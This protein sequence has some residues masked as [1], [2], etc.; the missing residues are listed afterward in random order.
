MKNIVITFIL[1]TFTIFGSAQEKTKATTIQRTPE[2]KTQLLNQYLNLLTSENKWLGSVYILQDG[3]KLYSYESGYLSDEKKEKA[4]ENT[5]Y[6][7][8]SVTK[9]FTASLIYQLI[10]RKKLTLDTKLSKFYPEIKH[11]DKITI[12]H[13][14]GHQ[15]GIFNYTNSDEIDFM[16]EYSKEEM[17]TVLKGMKSTFEPGKDQQYSNSNYILLGF[18]I[19]DVL[20]M[21]LEKAYKKYIFSKG[22]YTK[23]M[24]FEQPT[25]VAKNYTHSFIWNEEE[26]TWK[27]VEPWGRSVAGAAGAISSSMKSLAEFMGK[28]YQG[29]Y[30]S[31]KSFSQMIE[32]DK[33]LG[34]GSMV[35]PFYEKRGYGHGGGIEEFQTTATY[36]PKDKISFAMVTNGVEISANDVAIGILSIIFDKEFTLPTF[37]DEPKQVKGNSYIGKFYNGKIKLE[38]EVSKKD[39]QYYAQATGQGQFQIHETSEGVFEQEAF[40]IKLEFSGFDSFVLHQGGMKLTFKRIE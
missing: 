19:E 1:V 3:E 38:V 17:L 5:K 16:K 24:T 34:Y 22:K 29:D 20:K 39:E 32:V 13:L 18:I 9:M 31:Q 10:D 6:R 37:D 25:S 28:W 36:F 2:E 30:C 35:I 40:G 27:Q 21:P 33:I 14:L 8:G 11:A 12:K 15:T 23:E 4:N 26:N 7:I